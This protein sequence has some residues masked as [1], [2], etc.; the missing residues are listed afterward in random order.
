MNLGRLY[1]LGTILH[2]L[3]HI[4]HGKYIKGFKGEGDVTTCSQ[5]GS[6]LG[7]NSDPHRCSKVKQQSLSI[8]ISPFQV[9]MYTQTILK[10]TI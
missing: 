3:P 4:K 5:Q 8:A 9:G 2:F 10:Y 7:T 6:Q 1:T